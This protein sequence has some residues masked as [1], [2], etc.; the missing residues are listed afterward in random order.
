MTSTTSAESRKAPRKYRSPLHAL[1]W[2]FRKSRENWKQKCQE[3]NRQLRLVSRRLARLA[4]RTPAPTPSPTSSAAASPAAAAPAAALPA[5]SAP[6]EA[7]PH[8]SLFLSFLA[9][10]L[11]AMQQQVR[12]N[13]E[14][15]PPPVTTPPTTPLPTSAAAALPAPAAPLEAGSH[16]LAFLA[17][18]L[19]AM[20]QQVRDNREL[21]EQMQQQPA[22]DIRELLQQTQQQQLEIRDL[23]EQLR[24]R[25]QDAEAR[26]ATTVAA[27]APPLPE[28]SIPSSAP[29][30]DVSQQATAEP[31]KGGPQ[32]RLH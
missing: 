31:K 1:I 4:S 30:S 18:E 13:R 27:P 28:H 12:D 15:L 11:Q 17:A 14:L 25:L 21:L 26:H 24:R 22:P 9:T 20:Q 32:Q 8:I 2:S 16:I 10:E 6:L 23:T 19:P 3:A 29:Q 5:P 7:T